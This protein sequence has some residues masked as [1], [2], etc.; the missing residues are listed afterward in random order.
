MTDH[1]RRR[2][3]HQPPVPPQPVNRVTLALALTN[4]AAGA[5][6]VVWGLT[7]LRAPLGSRDGSLDDVFPLLFVSGLLG[8]A[9]PK[10]VTAAYHRTGSRVLRVVLDVVDSWTPLMVLCLTGFF[11]AAKTL[12]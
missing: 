1:R 12:H 7:V 3:R 6:V 2:T 8:A 5:L 11:V 4:A 9:R 10:S